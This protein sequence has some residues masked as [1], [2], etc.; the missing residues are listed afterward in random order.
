MMKMIAQFTGA[1]LVRLPG[2]WLLASDGALQLHNPVYLDSLVN[3]MQV[4]CAYGLFS[5]GSRHEMSTQSKKKFREQL[6][7]TN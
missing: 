5:N 2:V 1:G 4:L 6:P 3:T 7:K